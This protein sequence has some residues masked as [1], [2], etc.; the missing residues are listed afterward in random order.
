MDWKEIAE[1][2]Y[3]AL[4]ILVCLRVIYDTRTSIK[5][6]A[7]LLLIILVPVGGMIIYFSFGINYRK[8]RLYSRKLHEDESMLERLKKS[9]IQSS[10]KALRYHEDDMKDYKELAMLLLKDL[11]SPLADNNKVSLLVNGDEKFPDVLEAFRQAKDHIHIEYYIIE[12]GDIGRQIEEI[13]I[14]KVKEGVKVRLIYDDFGSRSARRTL[15]RRLRDGGVEAFPYHKVHFIL[16]A[17]RLNYRNH[18]KIIVIDGNISFIGGIN[19][20]DRYINNKPGKLFWRDTHIRIEGPG[21]YYLQYIF[22][23]DWNFCSKQ[24]LEP[25]LPYFSNY[26]YYPSGSLVQIA[27]S[28]PDYPYP[29]ILFSVLE[30]VYMAKQ[31]ILITTPYFIPGDSLL[32]ALIIAQL[33]NVKV[34]LLVPDVSDLPFVN[35]AAQAYYEDLLNAGIEIYQYKKGFIHSKSLVIDGSLSIVGTAN[36]DP[37]SFELNFEVNAVVYDTEFSVKLRNLFFED[38]KDS[39]QIDAKIWL[40]RP[41]YRKFGEKLVRLI[42]PLL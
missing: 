22:L 42:S 8:R 6:V 2:L 17:N 20:S 30:A 21:V 38:L 23:T 9:I 31:E 3:I 18:R 19:I 16:L 14:A 40:D 12:D 1:W 24:K 33:G 11:E 29:S 25:E 10:I 15:I 36:I 4:L 7:Y 32:E 34:K 41:V 37:R 39:E 27:A 13:L 35:I 28:G 5:T 26:P